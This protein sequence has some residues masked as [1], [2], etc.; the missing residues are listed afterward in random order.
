M[1]YFYATKIK[2]VYLRIKYNFK[3]INELFLKQETN[4]LPW[5]EENVL[6]IDMEYIEPK[7]AKDRDYTIITFN[8]T[9][10]EE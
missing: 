9:E 4:D 2:P 3:Y 10:D 1:M 7:R 5:E 6:I 8:N